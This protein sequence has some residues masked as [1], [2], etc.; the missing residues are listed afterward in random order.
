MAWPTGSSHGCRGL[1]RPSPEE[2]GVSLASRKGDTVSASSRRGASL[3]ACP[4]GKAVRAPRSQAWA[5]GA[6]PRPPGK[7]N[8]PN[9][10]RDFLQGVGFV[11]L[12]RPP[13]L[14]TA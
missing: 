2:H 14:P 13:T 10:V 5:D 6:G 12:G 7:P 11:H 3:T 9:G 4:A 1:G 8:L